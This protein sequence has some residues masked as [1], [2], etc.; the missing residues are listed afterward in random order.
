MHGSTNLLSLCVGCRTEQL[1]EMI[2]LHMH[3][4]SHAPRDK[5]FVYEDL[6]F[7]SIMGIKNL[8]LIKINTEDYVFL[9]HSLSFYVKSKYQL[10]H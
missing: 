4:S 3:H 9:Q 1:A 8:I 7:L 10:V 6:V 2:I 5:I